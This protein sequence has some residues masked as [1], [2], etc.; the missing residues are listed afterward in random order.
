[1]YFLTNLEK[2]IMQNLKEY[3]NCLFIHIETV[4]IHL[5]TISNLIKVA[6]T[7][8]TGSETTGVT[9]F[10]YLPLK[11]KTGIANRML[12]PTL[13]I[14]DPLTLLHLPNRVACY[15]GFDVLW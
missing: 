15:S 9:V 8:G 2:H 7:A 10:D 6:T 14:V 1:M 11:A 13:G 4:S 12:R 5:L 3:L